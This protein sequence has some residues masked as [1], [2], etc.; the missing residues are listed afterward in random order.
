MSEEASE[1]E[2]QATAAAAAA[3]KSQDLY[4]AMKM[5]TG[6]QLSEE[7]D[8]AS[9]SVEIS[10]DE[11]SA[12]QQ[13]EEEEEEEQQPEVDPHLHSH[14]GAAGVYLPLQ[15]GSSSGPGGDGGHP[16]SGAYPAVSHPEGAENHAARLNELEAFLRAPDA[17]MEPN[18]TNKLREYIM[19]QG[20]PPQAVEF[21]T[22]GYVGE[23]SSRGVAAGLHSMHAGQVKLQAACGRSCKRDWGESCHAGGHV[24]IGTPCTAPSSCILPASCP[25]MQ[26][27]PRWPAWC[28]AGCNGCM[29]PLLRQRWCRRPG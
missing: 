23:G 16:S 29:K 1:T 27:M 17:I 25:A 8:N 24:R 9:A 10:Q 13:S 14:A 28:A 4:D 11:E 2:E 22:E 26:A 12:E 18:I 20:K 19:A 21:L 6:Y 5:D 7:G 15:P 3:E